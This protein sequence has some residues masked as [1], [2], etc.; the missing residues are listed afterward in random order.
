[1]KHGCAK[2]SGK[3]RLYGVWLR[4]K[5]RC[6]YPN[7]TGYKDYGGRGIG[8][9]EEW[10]NSYESFRAWAL[11]NGYDP[12]AP[13]GKCMI[14]RIDVNKDYCPENCKWVDRTEQAN[15]TRRNH[16]ITFQ[17]ET[18]TISQWGEKL[19]IDKKKLWERIYLYEMPPEKALST[20]KNL[21]ETYLEYNNEVHNLKEWSII[22]GIHV[23]TL[24]SRLHKLHWSIEKTL[25]T[26]SK[27]QKARKKC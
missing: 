8:I 22:T 18:L 13:Y 20:E 17:G 25:T 15:N 14:E 2:R 26:P 16:F 7:A 21:G 24:S 11:S 23:Q 9:C 5:A 3:E 27:K 10:K 19:G 1:M 6:L 12:N 4:I